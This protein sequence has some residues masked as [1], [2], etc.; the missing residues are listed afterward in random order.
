MGTF[1]ANRRDSLYGWMLSLVTYVSI[2][3]DCERRIIPL[4]LYTAD[5]RVVAMTLDVIDCDGADCLAATICTR[6]G[7]FLI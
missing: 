5:V 3:K 1:L 7:I 4:F 6:N 2:N